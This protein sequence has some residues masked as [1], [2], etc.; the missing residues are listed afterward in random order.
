[1]AADLADLVADLGMAR[2]G[3]AR[4]RRA[5]PEEIP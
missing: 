3:N 1:M 4:G 2:P 5:Y